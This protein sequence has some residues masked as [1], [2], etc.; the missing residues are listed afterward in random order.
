MNLEVY[1]DEL[2]NEGL[3]RNHWF[4]TKQ[5]MSDFYFPFYVAKIV[6]TYQA[7]HKPNQ[8]FA[9]Y[10]TECFKSNEETKEMYP[11]QC[12][13]ENTYRNAIIAEFTGLIERKSVQYSQAKV[14][15]A[16]RRMSCYIHQYSDIQTHK[17]IV[18]RQIEKLALNVVSSASKY[19]EVKSVT[20]FPIVFL[21]KVLLGLYEKYKDSTLTHEEF[22]VFVM[23]TKQYDEYD[24]VIDLIDQ[25]RRHSYSQEYDSKIQLVMEHQSTNN[26]RF[27]S[28]IGSLTHI[29][30]KSNKYYKIL[31]N[32]ESFD[33]IKKV[34]SMFETS[35]WKECLNKEKILKFM[36]SEQ[37]FKGT[38][39]NVP[40]VVTVSETEY[41]KMIV[42]ENDFIDKLESLA[43]QYGISGTTNIKSEV[44]LSSVQ[45]VFRDKLIEKHGQK[46][47]LCNITNKDM[48]I[49]SH[50]KDAASC[51][52]FEKADFNN[53]LLLCANHDKLFDKFLITFNFYDGKIQISNSLTDEEKRICM[54]NENICLEE[55]VLTD[56]TKD[57]LMWHN[58]EFQKLEQDRK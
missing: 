7:K 31:N 26:V 25:Y 2:I 17:D 9:S 49:A 36:Q 37:Y 29:D 34:V 24:Q 32:Q 43:K 30:Y 33:Y 52:I 47:L 1:I 56:K 11:K 28:L 8:N 39:D 41:K 20:I 4:M 48:L 12:E 35:E 18:D 50:I 53:G 10:Y 42:E 23:R 16:Y 13:S 54:L 19:E 44:R 51:D 40:N 38:I 21:Y 58:E 3:N 57:Y 27:D 14:T 6:D 45:K 22:S 46:C 55:K 15:E 5:T